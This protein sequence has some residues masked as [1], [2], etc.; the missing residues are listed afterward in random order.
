[1]LRFH[2]RFAN[3]ITMLCGTEVPSTDR[4]LSCAALIGGVGAQTPASIV[5]GPIA[6]SRSASVAASCY[7]E[8]WSGAWTTGSQSSISRAICA[9]LRRL[10]W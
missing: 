2:L 10:I 7:S 5:H 3:I 6:R 9:I 1:M 8:R 4:V